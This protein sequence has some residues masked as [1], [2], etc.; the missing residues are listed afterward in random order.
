MKEGRNGER[1]RLAQI[2]MIGTCSGSDNGNG[3][4]NVNTVAACRT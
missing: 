4:G 1:G 2:W 3:N